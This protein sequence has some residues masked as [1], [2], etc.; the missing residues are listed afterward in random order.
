MAM[1]V[2]SQI[3][4]RTILDQVGAEKLLGQG[5]MLFLSG[6]LSKPTRLLSAFV[7]EDEVKKVVE[8]L[9]H[10]TH[11]LD[12]IDFDAKADNGSESSIYG[13]ELDEDDEDELYG[14]AK[15]IVTEAGKASTSF[16]QRR[17]RIGYSRAARLIDLLEERG[18]IGGADGAKPREIL[19][20]KGGAGDSAE[21]SED[22]KYV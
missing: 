6:E 10:Q 11:T 17:L 3:D 22:E 2:A 14:E 15:Q 1:Q 21:D 9:K 12:S 16:L 18:V 5:D 8:F 20:A 13:S 4:S 19:G 7:S